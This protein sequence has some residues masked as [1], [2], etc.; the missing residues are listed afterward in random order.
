M[1]AYDV[2]IIGAG[3]GG[4]TAAIRSA[5][6]GLK[7]AIVEKNSTLGG[8]CLN[9]GCIPSKALLDTSEKFHKVS[10]S[11]DSHGISLKDVSIDVKKMITRKDGIVKEI[12]Q[13]V[14]LLMKKN[15]IRTIRGTGRLIGDS[16]VAI[17]GKAKEIEMEAKHIVLA[18]GSVPIELPFLPFD[19]KQ[20]IS[21]T[22]ALCLEEVPKRL[23]V[24][25]AGAIGL[26]LGSVWRS[27]GAEVKVVE[28][29]PKIAPFADKHI[30]TLLKKELE[31]QGFSF[32]LNS[33]VSGAKKNGKQVSVSIQ[34]EKGDEE[35]MDCSILLVAVG[36]KPFTDGLGLEDVGVKTDKAGRVIIDELWRTSAPNVYAVGDIVHG[37]MLAHK[38]EEEGIA[39]VERL[40]G[41]AGHVNYNVIPNVIYTH[42][43]L[44]S[45][46]LTEEAAKEQK[47]PYKTGRSYF[48]A[49]ARAKCMS[50]D[51]G[52]VKVIAH[53]ETDR[54]LGVHILGASA[55]ELI[56]EAVVT[57][58]FSGSAEDLART[59]HAHPTL[60][61]V[62]KEAA[63]AV[64]RRSING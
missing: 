57:M 36:R 19:Q 50:A 35:A 24:V 62:V 46:G 7:T 28:L 61:E 39:L 53:K 17:K 44:A 41:K 9:V 37:P 13:G 45:V 47:I 58:E 16:K 10:G 23:I 40:A 54:L 49:N 22:E 42:P 48:R 59:C 1:D 32:Y 30:S 51:E 29:L 64:D 2:V 11:L 52:M 31:N 8:T 26:E 34:N 5:Q 56:H 4:Y 3:P 14:S 63:L 33:K 25:G 27:L 20:I 12:T 60:S 18:T 38:A 15:K 6:L 43:E 21:S 55:S